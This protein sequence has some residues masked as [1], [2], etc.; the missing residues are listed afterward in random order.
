MSKRNE[1]DVKSK[2]Q[3]C[4]DGFTID[5][6]FKNL[7]PPLNPE[8]FENLEKSILRDGCRD[9]LVIWSETGILIDGYHRYEICTNHGHSFKIEK[10]SFANR[11][12]ALDWM[13]ENQRIRRNMNRFQWAEVVL[14][15]KESIAAKAK[16][17]QK[18]GGG[19]VRTKSYEPV[20]TL[21]KLAKLAGMG[22]STL[23]QVAFILKHA[24]QNT[25]AKLRKGNS[26]FS[27]NSVHEELHELI[28]KK[29]T[30]KSLRAKPKQRRS[31]SAPSP[32]ELPQ[33]LVGHTVATLEELEQQYPELHDR[34]DFYN[35]VSDWVHKK[36]VELTLSQKK[37]S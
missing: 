29:R 5:E 16:A 33:D 23:R 27:I 25:I 2:M 18:A 4:T 30:T 21:E 6:E 3:S 22:S 28:D 9:P 31:K 14:K 17:N 1:T 24:D 35:T 32:S 26:N 11:D 7:L 19:A 8:D 34:I 37:L 10:K 12:Q 20:K 13:I 36:K 15:R